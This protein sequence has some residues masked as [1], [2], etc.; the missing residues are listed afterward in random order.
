MSTSLASAGDIAHPAGPLFRLFQVDSF[1]A[2]PFAGNPA[3]V[4]LAADPV[5]DPVSRRLGEE[6][7]QPVTALV[8]PAGTPGHF[9]LRWFAPGGELRLCGHGTLA[10]A[11]VLLDAELGHEGQVRFDTVAGPLTARADGDRVWLAFPS[12]P[13]KSVVD[14]GVAA[15]VERTLGVRPRE[16]LQNE[17][18]LVAVLDAEELVRAASPDPASLASLEVR[19]L[20]VTAASGRAGVDF[21]SRFFHAADATEDAVTGSAHCALAPLWIRRLGRA[22]LVGHQVSARGGFVTVA[23]DGDRVILGGAAVVL[24]EGTWRVGA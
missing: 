5:P 2:V 20:I 1:T 4:V 16:V 19:G 10:A 3:A 14:L 23:H 15:A 12:L 7:N 21:V 9:A 13:P 24:G 17:F 11:R 18:D 8:W 22:P 6:L